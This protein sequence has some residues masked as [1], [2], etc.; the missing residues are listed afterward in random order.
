MDEI[1]S[2]LLAL[3]QEDAS[4]PLKTLAAAVGLARSSVRERIARLEASGTIRRYT[5]E[6]AATDNALTAILRL[7]LA[8]TPAPETVRAVVAMPEVF[9]CRSLSGDIDLLVEISG[10][11]IAAINRTRD[12]IALLTD[13]VD[14]ET[15]FVLNI[16][17]ALA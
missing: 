17:K 4:R 7:R 11:D 8:R 15:A 3:L 5:I 1:D 14:V 9:R 2:R 16:D 13:V 10:T 6:V 12:R